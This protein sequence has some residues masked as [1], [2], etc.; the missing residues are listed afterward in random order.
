MLLPF[1]MVLATCVATAVEKAS[2]D[3]RRRI[4]TALHHHADLDARHI[5]VAV[6]DHTVTLTGT[7][8]TWMQRDNCRTRGGKRPRNCSCGD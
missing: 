8:D 1:V 2:R 6:H 5:R 4:V 3:V 7:V